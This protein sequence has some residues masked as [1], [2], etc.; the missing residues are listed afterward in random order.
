L[1]LTD[2]MSSMALH[3]WAEIALVIFQIVFV[4]VVARVLFAPKSEVKRI[5]SL[6]LEDDSDFRLFEEVE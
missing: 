3:V 5:A 6:P 1:R 4:L 2:I